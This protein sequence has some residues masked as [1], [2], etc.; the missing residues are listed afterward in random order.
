MS[1]PFHCRMLL[2]ISNHT[3][4]F[5]EA[6]RNGSSDEWAR[7]NATRFSY[8]SLAIADAYNGGATF[9]TF[10]AAEFGEAITRGCFGV[11][12]AP[13]TRRWRTRPNRIRL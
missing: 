10:L 3:Q 2:C 9:M 1:T 8:C 12:Q 7:R 5:D 13:S 11:P 4:S 6:Q